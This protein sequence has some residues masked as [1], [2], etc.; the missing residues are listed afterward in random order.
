ME[1][2]S[3]K[4]KE[5]L[6]IINEEL[7]NENKEIKDNKIPAMREPVAQTYELEEPD[8]LNQSFIEY[9]VSDEALQEINRVAPA[10][11]N[12]FELLGSKEEIMAQMETE[13][14]LG[15]SLLVGKVTEKSKKAAREQFRDKYNNKVYERRD[16]LAGE[17][18]AYISRNRLITE[19]NTAL[20]ERINALR[21]ERRANKALSEDK[22]AEL[23]KLELEVADLDK[24]KNKN[25][26]I[27]KRRKETVG[28]LKQDLKIRFIVANYREKL[29]KEKAKGNSTLMNNMI[30]KVEAFDN[31]VNSPNFDIAKQYS[32][33]KEFIEMRNAIALYHDKNKGYKWFDKG[34][35]RRDLAYNFLKNLNIWIADLP[36]E[37]QDTFIQ[38][39]EKP[40]Y[41]QVRLLKTSDEMYQE[42]GEKEFKAKAAESGNPNFKVSEYVT[43]L[44]IRMMLAHRSRLRESEYAQEYDLTQVEQNR[45]LAGENNKDVNIKLQDPRSWIYTFIGLKRNYDG[46]S[47][48]PEME[49]IIKEGVSAWRHNDLEKMK[50]FLDK[51]VEKIMSYNVNLEDFLPSNIKKNGPTLMLQQDLMMSIQN[52]FFTEGTIG[53]AY[54]KEKG[55]AFRAKLEMISTLNPFIKL[56][57]TLCGDMNVSTTGL[58]VGKVAE[59]GGWLKANKGKKTEAFISKLIQHPESVL[60]V[61]DFS[62]E[63]HG[64]PVDHIPEPD[65]PRSFRKK[66]HVNRTDIDETKEFIIPDENNFISMLCG[67]L[68]NIIQRG[69]YFD[70]I[71][72]KYRKYT[73]AKELNAL[74]ADNREH[75]EQILDVYHQIEVKEDEVNNCRDNA[76]KAQLK[77][78]LVK[79][80]EQ[81]DDF[82]RFIEKYHERKGKAKTNLPE[83]ENRFLDNYFGYQNRNPELSNKYKAK[84]TR[85]DLRLPTADLQDNI[86][87]QMNLIKKAEFEKKLNQELP[88]QDK[89]DIYQSYLDVQ[90]ELIKA[91][92]ELTYMQE[93]NSDENYSVTAVH[94]ELTRREEN[95]PEENKTN[96]STYLVGKEYSDRMPKLIAN[97]LKKEKD[98]IDLETKARGILWNGVNRFA[99]FKDNEGRQLVTTEKSNHL[100]TVF[101]DFIGEQEYLNALIAERTLIITDVGNL[102]QYEEAFKVKPIFEYIN[103]AIKQQYEDMVEVKNHLLELCKEEFPELQDADI[104]EVTGT[105]K[106]KIHIVTSRGE[107]TLAEMEKDEFVKERMYALRA[108]GPTGME[109]KEEGAEVAYI[110][111]HRLSPSGAALLRRYAVPGSKDEIALRSKFTSE[112]MD[113]IVIAGLKYVRF[114]ENQKVLAEDVANE[115]WNKKWV[116]ACLSEDYEHDIEP[117]LEK[118]FEESLDFANIP[119]ADRLSANHFMQDEKHIQEY[120]RMCKLMLTFDSN[121]L[122]HPSFNK[123]KQDYMNG[124]EEKRSKW[125]QFRAANDLGNPM[126]TILMSKIEEDYYLQSDISHPVKNLVA[127]ST[128]KLSYYEFAK[129]YIY[130][131]EVIKYA[132]N[133]LFD[134]KSADVTARMAEIP[135]YT[136]ENADQYTEFFKFYAQVDD[137]DADI[138]EA[139]EKVNEINTAIANVQS[140][141]ESVELSSKKD[142]MLA[143]IRE[144]EAD[145][146]KLLAGKQEMLDRVN[147]VPK[148]S[149]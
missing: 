50:P 28:I 40:E 70:D 128:T 86:G 18:N 36:K 17:I 47:A 27:I 118:M 147:Q 131:A 117:L 29:E 39:M 8:L 35:Y 71:N 148:K 2:F 105:L 65:S 88:S 132:K 94:E 109:M 122:N 110:R 44:T 31:L 13:M 48:S 83:E 68:Q 62:L 63:R 108:A 24:L 75:E 52:V 25:V 38:E 87:L 82:V 121:I 103:Q 81:K 49:N 119:Y 93:Q 114:D 37:I 98:I 112:N 91:R 141:E 127:A 107:K 58:D 32:Y 123:F 115:E 34:E 136:F 22:E 76:K 53:E 43:P 97:T 129:T 100:L 11:N 55:S 33:I 125:K 3:S 77:A 74:I 5:S 23:K 57:H 85:D 95:L 45:I 137:F 30:Q 145:K 79:L 96:M 66:Y 89:K 143:K 21:A 139:N 133:K 59:I 106:N 9:P 7:I 51:M 80:H 92:E 142:A 149:N 60:N 42:L 130:P 4:K 69:E 135:N 146:Q 56:F 26:S 102:T 67:A 124:S 14:S 1:G 6:S 144:Y 78:E 126:N 138:A 84:R 20:Q 104:D 15:T 120:L 113:R 64:L 19:R 12:S 72:T 99:G 10:D 111:T 101:N 140:V 116:K 41:E 61:A 90:T 134:A 16:V 46:T 54:L 73:V